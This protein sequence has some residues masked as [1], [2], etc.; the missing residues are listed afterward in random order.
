MNPHKFPYQRV[1]VIG[2]T[3]SG[4]STLVE[5]LEQHFGLP[6]MDLDALHWLPNWVNRPTPEFRVLVTE[7]TRTDNWAL[8]G[9]YNV[10]RDIIWSRAQAIIWLD[11]PFWTI[12]W[13]LWNR[14]WRR[15]WR[16]ELL[17]GTNYERITSQFKLWSPEDSIFRWLFETYWRRK[18]EIPQLLAQP[19]YSH[20]QIVHLRSRAET[21]EWLDGFLI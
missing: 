18:R 20:L 3:G 15:W 4:K 12:F 19:E 13:Q 8:A 21:K 11:Y 14:T 16:R 17:W 10:V 2:A 5:K 9:N 7:V 6:G 1:I